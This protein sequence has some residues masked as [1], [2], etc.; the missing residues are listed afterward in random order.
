MC[1]AYSKTMHS[2]QECLTVSTDSFI[3]LL[4]EW[5]S[6]NR[7]LKEPLT[8]DSEFV[9]SIWVSDASV[10]LQTCNYGNDSLWALHAYSKQGCL[11]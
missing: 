11:I 2:H 6:V 10:A 8:V 1:Y 3:D 7:V 4:T 5:D 9:L